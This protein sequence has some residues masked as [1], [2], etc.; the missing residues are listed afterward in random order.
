[1]AAPILSERELNIVEIF[2][3][4][5]LSRAS[6]RTLLVLARGG[7]MVSTHIEAAAG[8]RQPEVS[9]ALKEMRSDGW[10]TK[11]DQRGEGKGRP[12]HLYRLAVPIS[13]IV[14]E[15]EK[16]EKARIKDIESN[17]TALRKSLS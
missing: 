6:A 7:E 9:M 13:K 14:G 8:L 15:I 16:K 11:R 1:M 4:T 10:V 17:I 5:G 3:K 12:T 2:V